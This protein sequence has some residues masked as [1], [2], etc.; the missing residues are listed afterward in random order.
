MTRTEI[1]KALELLGSRPRQSLGQNFLHDKNLARWIVAQLDIKSGEHIVE[2][3][4]GLGALTGLLTGYDISLTLIEKDRRMVKWL[5]ENLDTR[6]VEL[7]HDDAL[8]ID[9]RKLYGKGPVKV[10]G[11]LPY[12]VSTPL[13]AKYT[14]ALSPASMLVLT[15]QKEVAERLVAL[16]RTKQ[17]GAMTVCASRRWT[18]RCAKKFPPSVFHPQPQVASAVVVFERKASGCIAP[19]DEVLFEKLVRRGF[20]ERRKQLRN[21]LIEQKHRWSELCAALGVEET[22]RAEELSLPQWERLS[23]LIRPAKAQHGEELF[24][25]VDAQDRVIGSESRDQVHVNNL[26]HRAIHVLI[27]N[28]L[29]EVFLQKRSIWKDTNPGKWDSSA[30]GHVDAGESYEEAAR[31]ELREEIGIDCPI[32]RIAKLPC[33]GATG[34]EFIEVFRGAHE[35]PFEPAPLELETGAFFPLD[36]IRNWVE[37]SPE[38]FSPVFAMCLHLLPKKD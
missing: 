25:V 32:E 37:R 7:F 6:R 30:A 36:Q 35:G 3:G 21:L 22:V 17:F 24:C 8:N 5:R 14:S 16:P 15:L 28:R 31:R 9:L 1:Q 18:I 11:N 33:S 38:D 27:F 19:C 12:Y 34:W 29:G 10:V 13:I 26:R 23:Q 20:S 4:P 2:I